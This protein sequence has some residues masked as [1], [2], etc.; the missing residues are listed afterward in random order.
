LLL[1]QNGRAH[2]FDD[3]R[4]QHLHV[5]QILCVLLLLAQIERNAQSAQLLSTIR[6]LQQLANLAHQVLRAL[7]LSGHIESSNKI[8]RRSSGR[9][10]RR[11]YV[12]KVE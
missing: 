1:V 8:H 6:A 9:L 10:G 11:S 2:A 4:H 7:S 12:G 3:V 5:G